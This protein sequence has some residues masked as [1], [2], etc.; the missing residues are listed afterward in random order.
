M[1]CILASLIGAAAGFLTGCCL[2]Y[3]ARRHDER[4]PPP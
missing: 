3:N 1:T 2:G 4:Q